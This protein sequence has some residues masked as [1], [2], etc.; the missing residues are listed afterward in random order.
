[1]CAVFHHAQ[2]MF[3]G[4]CINRIE[5]DRRACEMH[6][7]DG[8]G[9]GRDGGFDFARVHVERAVRDIDQHRLGPGKH[10]GVKRGYKSERRGDDLVAFFQA[11]RQKS[12]MKTGSRRGYA[13]GF[14]AAVIPGKH[15]LEFRHTRAG[16]D[17]AG[18][19]RGRDLGNRFF[20]DVRL[21]EGQEWQFFAHYLP[22]RTVLRST[23]YSPIG[24]SVQECGGLKAAA[25]SSLMNTNTCLVAAQRFQNSSSPI[26]HCLVSG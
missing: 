26:I 10:D 22:I 1:M 21:G 19:K 15:F 9:P 2:I 25:A 23:P 20:A 16:G 6:R 4:E 18:T 13:E 3:P 17:P 14:P 5:I 24:C 12:D 11:Q 8:A 7:A